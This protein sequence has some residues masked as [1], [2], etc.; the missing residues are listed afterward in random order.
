MKIL[1]IYKT[2]IYTLNKTLSKQI[3]FKFLCFERC[4]R[5]IVRPPCREKIW[6]HVSNLFSTDKHWVAIFKEGGCWVIGPII[7][8]VTIMKKGVMLNWHVSL[9]EARGEIII[10][11]YY[12]DFTATQL[13]WNQAIMAWAT[14]VRLLNYCNLYPHVS[15]NTHIFAYFS[16]VRLVIGKFFWS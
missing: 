2:S 13:S 3:Y 16:G 10:F 8:L 4:E 6:P 15:V 9:L 11:L 1:L 7:S 5:L 12:P 14:P